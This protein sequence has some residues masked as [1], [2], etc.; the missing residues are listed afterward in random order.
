MIGTVA[1]AMLLIGHMS[2]NIADAALFLGYERLPNMYD[3]SV[4]VLLN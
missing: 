3:P 1:H 4:Y 2:W